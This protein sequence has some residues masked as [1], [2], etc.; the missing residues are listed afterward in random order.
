MP[1]VLLICE[2]ERRRGGDDVDYQLLNAYLND[3]HLL[4]IDIR[5]AGG[6]SSVKSIH[7]FYEAGRDLESTRD[8]GSTTRHVLSV[9]DRDYQLIEASDETWADGTCTRL[10]WH[11]HEIE[12]YLIAPAVIAAFARRSHQHLPG[13]PIEVDE[14][15]LLLRGFARKLCDH[16]AG[17]LLFHELQ[18]DIYQFSGGPSLTQPSLNGKQQ[19]PP[20]GDEW[21]RSLTRETKRVQESC[22]GIAKHPA[23]KHPQLTK[24]YSSIRDTLDDTYIQNDRYL[25]DFDGK[26]LMWSLWSYLNEARDPDIRLV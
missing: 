18:T 15:R 2:G 22:S 24:R 13:L 20:S 7:Q 12:N 9:R 3:A 8:V 23:W 21:I 17:R 25:F 1:E 19:P 5:P 14:I 4:R 11:R 16:H 26:E 6:G 10:I